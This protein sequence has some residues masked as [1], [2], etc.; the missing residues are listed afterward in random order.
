[1]G[2]CR[3]PAWCWQGCSSVLPSPR[4]SAP[5]CPGNAPAAQKPPA[6]RPAAGQGHEAK[7][8]QATFFLLLS[9]RGISSSQVMTAPAG[10]V[11]HCSPWGVM[12]PGPSSGDA[13]RIWGTRRGSAWG[14]CGGTTQPKARHHGAAWRAPSCPGPGDAQP[15]SRA[16]A[17][18]ERG[19]TSAPAATATGRHGEHPGMRHLPGRAWGWG[20]ATRRCWGCAT[21]WC[22][23]CLARARGRMGLAEPRAEPQRGTSRTASVLGTWART[24]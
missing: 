6:P 24:R 15:E 23:R 2:T 12:E 10:I 9:P 18:G 21:Q 13:R 14:R 16:A 5:S 17:R 19:R 8:H 22:C 7:I 20:R 3:P 1:M 11:L 4:L